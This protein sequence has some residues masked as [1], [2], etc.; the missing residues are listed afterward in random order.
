MDIQL[1]WNKVKMDFLG[2]EGE[3]RESEGNSGDGGV[4]NRIQQESF[5]FETS[6]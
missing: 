5:G 3:R 4:A 2:V 6:K 1:V